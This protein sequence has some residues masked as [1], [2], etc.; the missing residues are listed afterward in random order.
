MTSF[1]AKNTDH[2]VSTSTRLVTCLVRMGV[3][4]D[5]TTRS[6]PA[7]SPFQRGRVD[8]SKR[9]CT[10]GCSLPPSDDELVLRVGSSVQFAQV[11]LRFRVLQEEVRVVELARQRQAEVSNEH[12]LFGCNPRS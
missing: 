10:V 7:L 11:I 12:E 9:M 6:G 2:R 8:G 4:V 5:A 1:L 3:G